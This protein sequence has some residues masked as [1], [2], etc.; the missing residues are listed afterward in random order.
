MSNSFELIDVTLRDG[1]NAV[2]YQFS[3][4]DTVN[5]VKGLEKGGI[6]WMEIG[7]GLGLGATERTAKKAL[8]SDEEYI[9]SARKA[10]KEMKIG[11]FFLHTIGDKYDI[12]K[13]IDCGLDFLRV[14]PNAD[15]EEIRESGKY[16]E[17]AKSKGL[18]VH[19][20]IRKAYAVTPDELARQAKV[21][22]AYGTDAVIIMD[23]AG[24]LLPNQ[25]KEYIYAMKDQMRGCT[26]MKVGYHAHDN[27]SLAVA[28]SLAAV[29]AG[30]DYIDSCLKGI[31]RSAGNAPTEILTAA[32]KRIGCDKGDFLILQDI[33][34]EYIGRKAS[35][36]L[37]SVSLSYGYAGF[38][39]AYYE[40][41]EK[42]AKE[43]HLDPRALVLET[44]KI[45][46]LSPTENIIGDIAK[47]MSG[48]ETIW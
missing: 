40:M 32:L 29:E 27:L 48:L 21:V 44:C 38:H 8:H 11:C 6:R 36:S 10:A 28:C 34:E 35:E 19:C 46:R 22:Q 14:G 33:A 12:D 17:Y 42:A 1:S 9:A 13:A 30:A 20:C 15:M 3:V 26:A 24:T 7:H 5:I 16:I 43:Y 18:I 41:I 23:S 31:G 25:T 39:S 4:E 45:E 47:K 37:E 2:N